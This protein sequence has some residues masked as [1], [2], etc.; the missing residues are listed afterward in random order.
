MGKN[1]KIGVLAECAVMLGL[2]TALSLVKVIKMPFGGSVTLMSMLPIAVVSIRRG[3]K[4]G[5]PV[6]FLY[7]LIQFALD[8]GDVLTWSLTPVVFAGM[9]FLDYIF[10]FSVLG[11]AGFSRKKGYEGQLLGVIIASSLRFAFHFLSGMVLWGEYAKSYDWANGNVPLY[12]LVYNGAY[13]FPEIL[14]TAIG[15]ALVLKAMQNM[16][17]VSQR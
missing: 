4:W 16:K 11:L 6:A 5:L 1:Q 12:S 10:A 8:L 3:V 7:S 2:A 14:F 13:M 17:L 15:A 9:L